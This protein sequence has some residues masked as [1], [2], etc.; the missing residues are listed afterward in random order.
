MLREIAETW[1]VIPVGSKLVEFNG[2]INL[3]ES[4]ALL[5]RKLEHNAT[6]DDLVSTL[7]LE[8][9]ISESNAR[10]DVADF[11]DILNANRLIRMKTLSWNK[12]REKMSIQAGE[13]GIAI[14]GVFELTARCSL[15]CKMCYVCR[16]AKDDEAMAKER[17]CSD[18]VNLAR[19]A[20][21]AGMLYVLLTGGEV[22]LRND[23]REIYEEISMMG[24]IPTI[25]TNATLIT[26][27]VCNWISRMPPEK[28]DV[29]IYGASASSY[30]K[31]CGFAGG[32]E[33]TVRGIDLLIDAG[34]DVRLKTTVVPDNKH[35]Y[36]KLMAFAKERGLTLRFGY[37]ISPSRNHSGKLRELSR[38]NPE[39]LA[40]YMYRASCDFSKS[41]QKD[42]D[43]SEKNYVER[44]SEPEVKQRETPF[45]CYVGT[46]DFWIT[47][48]GMMVPCGL[49]EEP[50]TFPFE[51]GFQ[52]AWRSLNEKVLE[53]SECQ[54]C[55]SCSLKEN[56]LTCPARLRN[57]TGYYDRP[58][59]YVCELAKQQHLLYSKK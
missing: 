19:E 9:Q 25:Y 23:F 16:P 50:R 26:S 57:E 55:L 13:K 8:Y 32:Y 52:D 22:F 46:R 41:Q 56:C 15:Q 58:A 17:T 11:L 34:I 37:Y 48:D 4:G 38:L 18:W 36:E 54:T 30:K 35:D 6:E 10:R 5:W 3:S 2:I 14:S 59:S 31:V 47:W 12:F 29:T 21:D 20:R 1:V 24:L 27:E 33:K 51:S 28:V 39:E 45:K 53:V 7:L 49:M 44:G 40:K 42:N 43:I